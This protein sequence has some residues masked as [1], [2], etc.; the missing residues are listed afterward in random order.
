MMD[1]QLNRNRVPLTIKKPKMHYKI[2]VVF[3]KWLLAYFLIGFVIFQNIQTQ[4]NDINIPS[5]IKDL[6]T[7][8][9]SIAAVMFTYFQIKFLYYQIRGK[10]LDNKRKEIQIREH[11]EKIKKLKE[12]EQKS[13]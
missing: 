6:E 9:A 8:A 2:S 12:E 13:A 7:L 11:L 4:L 10:R 3:L 1:L 5:G